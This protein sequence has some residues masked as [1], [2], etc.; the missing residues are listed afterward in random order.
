MSQHEKMNKR[1]VT[2]YLMMCKC[3]DIAGRRG[4]D[5]ECGCVCVS[6]E[7]WCW[8]VGVAISLCLS[9]VHTPKYSN[10]CTTT[11]PHTHPHI[12]GQPNRYH[13]C[14]ATCFPTQ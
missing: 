1:E 11:H 4:V 8:Y 9:G 14:T 13:F 12:W 7:A 6:V 2:K 5:F 3:L 10:K